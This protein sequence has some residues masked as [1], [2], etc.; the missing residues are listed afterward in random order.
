MTPLTYELIDTGLGRKLERVGSLVVDRQATTAFWNKSL[1]DSDWAKA[2]AVHVRS[3]QGGGHWTFKSKE[4]APFVIE[5]GG[6]KLKIKLTSFGHF[7]LF[8]EQKSE[9]AFFKKVLA[10]ADAKKGRYLNLFGYTGASTMALALGGASEVVHL[11]AA[12]GV[13][14]WARD[15][16]E[17]NQIPKERLKFVT[18]DALTYLKREARRGSKYDGVVM[19]PPSFGRGPKKEVFKLEDQVIDLLQSVRA[20]LKDDF[21]LFHFSCHTPG[22]GPTNLA[23]LTKEFLNLSSSHAIESGELLIDESTRSLKM[24]VGA[25]CRVTRERA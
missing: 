20:V 9:W 6:Q 25:F 13:V 19:D 24:A 21:K 18:D 15:N 7:G 17:L 23:T 12:Q 8:A 1:K 10:N 5:Y 3:D 14:D 4:P 22:F 16:A 2:Q 11:D